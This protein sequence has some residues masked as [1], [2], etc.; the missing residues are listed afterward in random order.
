M[1]QEGPKPEELNLTRPRGDTNPIEFIDTKPDG[2]PEDITGFN[3]RMSIDTRQN[4]DDASTQVFQ[5]VGVIAL[6]TDGKVVFTPSEAQADQVPATYYCDIQ[7]VDGSSI[8]TMAKGKWEVP[9]DITKE[10]T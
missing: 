7:R 2:Q 6:G 3:Y 5:M 4:P 8:R 1:V 10:N 9:Q